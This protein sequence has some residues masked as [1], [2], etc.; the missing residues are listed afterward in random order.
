MPEFRETGSLRR[1]KK[2]AR[3]KQHRLLQAGA[4]LAAVAGILITAFGYLGPLRF[5]GLQ[6]A[7]RL[8]GRRGDGFPLQFSYASL[9]QAALVGNSL[10][11]LG[12][13]ALQV[14]TRG[15][16]E[17]MDEPQPFHSPALRAQGG[18]LLLFDRGSGNLALLSKTAALHKHEMERDI[19][20]VDLGKTG[21][22]AVATKA[23]NSACEIYAFDAKQNKRF[24][25]RCEKEYPGA[26]RLDAG[27]RALAM[28]LLGTEQAEIYT[29]F[30]EFAFDR[31]EPRIDL[32]LDGVWLYGAAEI[33]GGWL[34]V[35]DQA[36][37]II[38]RDAAQPTKLSYEGRALGGYAA[39]GTVCAVWLRDWDNRALLR[40][41]DKRGELLK[42]QRFQQ[43]PYGM[44]CANGTVYLRFADHIIRWRQGGFRQS[45]ELPSGT[46]DAFVIGNQ[47]YVL[48]L[49]NVELARLRWSA[50]EGDLLL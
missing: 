33:S 32:R 41:Y 28:C 13:T 26:L 12:P 27:G 49:R 42:E 46:Q 25:W 22:F 20:C 8:T 23:E 34:A 2:N 40:I 44:Q 39:D 43:Q 6:D 7:W 30:A 19:F 24:A 50:M 10:A 18:R 5:S 45:T 48:T 3:K 35:G 36:V 17:A 4:A 1:E 29:R 11:L 21:A 47:A 31:K 14:F 15:S 9:Q 37:Y 16:Y 38:K